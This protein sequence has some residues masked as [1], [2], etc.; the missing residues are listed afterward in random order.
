MPVLSRARRSLTAAVTL[1]LTA[2]SLTLYTPA[3]AVQSIGLPTFGGPAT[4]APPVSY[5]PGGVG[6]F[7]M[8]VGSTAQI[9]EFDKWM[10]R[11]WR[12]HLKSRYGL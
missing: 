7:L 9:T 2:T 4:P 12:R 11:D 1:L 3:S 6:G 5:T 8:K 10:F